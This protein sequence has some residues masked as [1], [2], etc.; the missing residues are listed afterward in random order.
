MVKFYLKYHKYTLNYNIII[1]IKKK[2]IIIYK[3]E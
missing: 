1:I 2:D 3:K